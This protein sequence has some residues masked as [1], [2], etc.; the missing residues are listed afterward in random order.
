MNFRGQRLLFLPLKH[1]YAS[2]WKNNSSVS[3]ALK[4]TERQPQAKTKAFLRCV[5]KQEQS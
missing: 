4:K 5:K 2:E 3:P 1:N